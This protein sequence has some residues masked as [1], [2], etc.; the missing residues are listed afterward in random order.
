MPARNPVQGLRQNF[1]ISQNRLLNQILNQILNQNSAQIG[2]K[3]NLLEPEEKILEPEQQIPTR[4]IP[5]LL[6]P[7]LELMVR[8]TA[9]CTLLPLK[10]L[11]NL[12]LQQNS[13]LPLI[14]N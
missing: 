7:L 14:L 10:I 8:E 2:L 5:G 6:P 11:F 1:K 3:E 12:R 9:N 13:P 4:H